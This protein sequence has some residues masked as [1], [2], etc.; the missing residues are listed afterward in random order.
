MRPFNIILYIFY[1]AI[2]FAACVEVK[3]HN[4]MPNREA[5]PALYQNTID[6]DSARKRIGLPQIEGNLSYEA[7]Y[8]YCFTDPP[9]DCARFVGSDSTKRPRYDSKMIYWDSI[10]TYLERNYFIGPSNE[11]LQIFFGYRGV[12]GWTHLGFGYGLLF[13][14]AG[15]VDIV[16]KEADSILISW[17]LAKF[18]TS[19]ETK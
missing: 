8:F 6:L 19:G 9:T 16:K 7:N 11:R 18:I 10:G 1:L 17:N 2:S 15:H 12:E 3:K 14:D 13:P 4:K 5:Y